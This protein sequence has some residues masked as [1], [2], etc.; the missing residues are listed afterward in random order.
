MAGSKPLRLV[1]EGQTPGTARGHSLPRR[2]T[3]GVRPRSCTCK[4]RFMVRS[5]SAWM[6]A[7]A[8][9]FAATCASACLADQLQWNSPAVCEEAVREIGSRAF[10]IS[11]CSLAGQDYVQLW[12]V[13]DAW[14]A[15]TSAQRLYEVNVCARQLYESRILLSPE[16]FPLPNAPSLFREVR[17]GRW[18]QGGIDLAYTYIHTGAN[19]F[20]CLGSVMGLECLVGVETIKLPPRVMKR[21]TVERRTSCR[22]TLES[23]VWLHPILAR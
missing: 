3:C 23:W 6:V 13:Q 22:G 5:G 21:A 4:L 20:R 8:L 14:V 12:L 17:H 19:A 10:L 2:A 9:V 7:L 15:E 16:D 18:F 1:Y 11:Y